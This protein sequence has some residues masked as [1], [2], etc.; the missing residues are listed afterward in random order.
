MDELISHMLAIK[1]YFQDDRRLLSYVSKRPGNADMDLIKEKINTIAHQSQID[2]PQPKNGLV[3]LTKLG[4]DLA[5][6]DGNLSVVGKVANAF[7]GNAFDLVALASKYCAAHAPEDYPLWNIHSLNVL[8]AKCGVIFTPTDYEE[9]SRLMRGIRSG[10]G[11][12]KLNFFNIN[13]FFWIYENQLIKSN[14]FYV[15]TGPSVYLN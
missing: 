4:L 13:K 10:N 3:Q 11:M 14:E 8:Q 1:G 15:P 5:F 9:Y 6:A 2:I 12:E 7:S